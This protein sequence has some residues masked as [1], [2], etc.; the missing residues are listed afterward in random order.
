MEEMNTPSNSARK[1]AAAPLLSCGSARVLAHG[2]PERVAC[3][4]KQRRRQVSAGVNRKLS[5]LCLRLVPL[6]RTHA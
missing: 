5:G 4:P 2:R 6:E 1:P 3:L